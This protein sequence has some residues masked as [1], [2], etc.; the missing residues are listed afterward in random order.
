MVE[1]FLMFGNPFSRGSCKKNLDQVFCKKYVHKKNFN[2]LVSISL[3][4][5]REE[6]MEMKN[7]LKVIGF[8]GMEGTLKLDKSDNFNNSNNKSNVTNLV[9]R[10]DNNIIKIDIN[11]LYGDDSIASLAKLQKIERSEEIEPYYIEKKPKSNRLE[12]RLRINHHNS[13]KNIKIEVNTSNDIDN[14][15]EYTY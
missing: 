4:R 2:D 8:K 5:F 14:N 1:V 15:N 13:N 7:S 3:D 6:S 11:N 12:L 9:N 10:S